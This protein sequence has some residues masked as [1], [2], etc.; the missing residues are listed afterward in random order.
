MY[1]LTPSQL[2]RL[3]ELAFNFDIQILVDYVEDLLDEVYREGHQD[4]FH[5]GY[6]RAA[7]DYY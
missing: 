6:D 2:A 1:S 5:E 7:E 4:G 3:R